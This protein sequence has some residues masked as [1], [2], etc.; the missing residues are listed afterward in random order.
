VD[1]SE[2]AAV[3]DRLR[4]AIKSAEATAKSLGHPGIGIAHLFLGITEDEEAKASLLLINLGL[5]V[6]ETRRE[7]LEKL[8]R[9]A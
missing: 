5:D 2:P 3:S 1:I 4:S 7:M 9:P 8:S 6:K